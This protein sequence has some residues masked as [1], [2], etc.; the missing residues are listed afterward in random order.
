V[1]AR[2]CYFLPVVAIFVSG[3]ELLQVNTMFCKCLQ[4]VGS[5]C[6]LLLIFSSGC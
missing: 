6:K 4:V 2:G 3:C 5:V 1:L